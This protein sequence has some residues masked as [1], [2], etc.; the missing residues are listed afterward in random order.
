MIL[1]LATSGIVVL[2]FVSDAHSQSSLSETGETQSPRSNVSQ[3]EL[4]HAID[5]STVIANLTPSDHENIKGQAEARGR[6]RAWVYDYHRY[7]YWLHF[8]ATTLIFIT[9]HIIVLAGLYFSWIQFRNVMN[10]GKSDVEAPDGDQ[11]TDL[12]ST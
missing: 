3:D 6:Y 1:V 11:P 9:V 8:V 5:K 7:S 10:D 2:G 12:P 4:A